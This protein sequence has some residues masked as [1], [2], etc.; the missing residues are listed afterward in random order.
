VCVCVCVCGCVR[1]CVCVCVCARACVCVCVCVRAC[2]RACVCVH[3]ST[4]VRACVCMC[5]HVCAC[6]YVCMCMCRVSSSSR[7]EGK[8]E[9][10]VVFSLPLFLFFFPSF[11]GGQN[12]I[13]HLCPQGLS[14]T[15]A[16]PLMIRRHSDYLLQTRL[17]ILDT[18]G[19]K[20]GP[21]R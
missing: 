8:Y 16:C 20:F 19:A 11:L 4:H 10:L 12:P 17:D 7:G 21:K 2:V 9:I 14:R 1:V 5:V 18:I 3:V 15:V 6:V 13:E